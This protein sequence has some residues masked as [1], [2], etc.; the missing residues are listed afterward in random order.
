[1]LPARALEPLAPPEARCAR[2]WLA[3]ALGVLVIAGLFALV[4]VIGRMPPFDRL[5]TDPLF[6]KR[7]LVVHVNLALVAWFYS[8]IAALLFLMPGRRAPGRVARASVH[9]AVL[10][11]LMMLMAAALPGT[12]PVLS[13]YIPMIDHWL[14]GIGQVAFG[15]GV[16][17]SFVGRRLVSAPRAA[18]VVVPLPDAAR[19]GLRTTAAALLLA[20]LTFSIAWW[21]LPGGVAP[22]VRYELLFW[23]GGHVLQLAC[24]AAMVSVW[25]VLLTSLLGRSP[26]SAPAATA[27]FA[28]LFAPWTF[29]P[30]L[31]L[32]GAWTSSYRAGVTHLMQWSIFPVVSI[33]L[34]LCVAALHRA[35]RAGRLDAGAFADPRL[36]GFAVSAALT[37]LGFALGAAIRGSNTMVPAHYHASI[38]GVTA[39]FMSTT[40]VLLPALGFS[41]ETR[42]VRRAAA[43]QPALYGIGQ[44][45]FASG[46]ALAGAYGMTRKSYGAEQA[47]RGLAESV[48]LGVMG[49]GGLIAVAGG[50]LFLGLVAAVWWRGAGTSAQRASQRAGG[51]WRYRWARQTGIES[52]RSRD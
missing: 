50:L 24:S 35:W 47:A 37:L 19:S 14:F 52:I 28:L 29:A 16:L 51:T 9:L 23:G 42:R 34:V 49:L 8:F 1:M 33:F 2:A 10:G 21:N 3:L 17:A 26:V 46:F 20:A 25:L 7:G 48:G 31:A 44:M 41:M 45:V 27:L 15:A 43:W 11:V 12:R 13:N 22:E 32:E 4:V 38:G 36:S 5:V 39:A 30:L 6:F 18:G 40:Y